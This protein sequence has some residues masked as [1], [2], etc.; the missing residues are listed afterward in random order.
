MKN[1]STNT[2]EVKIV[3]DVLNGYV[4]AFPG[5]KFETF[6]GKIEN[7]HTAIK[8]RNYWNANLRTLLP[9]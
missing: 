2:N 6:S 1:T 9:R 3:G 5:E 8:L 4:L 7:M